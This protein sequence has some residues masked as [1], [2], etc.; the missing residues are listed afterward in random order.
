M[1]VQLRLSWSE[2]PRCEVRLGFY[3]SGFRESFDPRASA[4]K[5]Q[6]EISHLGG[7]SGVRRRYINTRTHAASGL[8]HQT[9]CLLGS[10]LEVVDQVGHVLVVVVVRV[11]AGRRVACGTERRESH[12][13]RGLKGSG[14]AAPEYGEPLAL[15]K[16]GGG[17]GGTEGL[18]AVS[19]AGRASLVG[20]GEL[21]EVGQVVGAQLVDDAGQQVLQLCED[22][23]HAPASS[24]ASGAS[25][26]PAAASQPLRHAAP[27]TEDTPPRH[28]ELLAARLASPL[29]HT[30]TLPIRRHSPTG[31]PPAQRPSAL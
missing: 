14:G 6:K 11:R 7:K 16:A 15:E 10:L 26:S 12:I 20:L 25:A 29:S 21:L 31:A 9:K 17:A 22:K 27:A 8:A 5:S 13:G 18:E 1:H 3:L 28:Q 30:L 23:P 24:G 4:H 2:S 19:A